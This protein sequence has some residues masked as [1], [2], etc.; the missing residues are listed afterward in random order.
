MYFGNKQYVG[1]FYDDGT[2]TIAFEA[3]ALD[4]DGAE[5]VTAISDDG[6]Y[7]VVATAR[8]L[9]VTETLAGLTDPSRQVLAPLPPADPSNARSRRSATRC[10]CICSSECAAS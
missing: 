7:L 6:R 4:L 5:T 8:I 9:G 1:M 10:C 2:S 3:Q